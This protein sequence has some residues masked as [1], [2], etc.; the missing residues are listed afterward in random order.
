MWRHGH[1][2]DDGPNLQEKILQQWGMFG[3]Q[4]QNK[5]FKQAFKVCFFPPLLTQ[6]IQFQHDNHQKIFVV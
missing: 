4:N 5:L 6:H 2:F 1:I 3:F